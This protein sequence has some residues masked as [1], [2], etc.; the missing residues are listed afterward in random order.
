MLNVVKSVLSLALA[1]LAAAALLVG[2]LTGCAGHQPQR[3]LALTPA[4]WKNC[5][6]EKLM[7]AYVMAKASSSASPMLGKVTGQLIASECGTGGLNA[8]ARIAHMLKTA[9]AMDRDF[10]AFV[11]E[12]EART[13][14]APADVR[15]SEPVN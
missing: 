12:L 13:G 14:D 2:A 5:A 9:E 10:A 7:L 15:A 11:Q 4:E 8:A 3:Q 1:L 6:D